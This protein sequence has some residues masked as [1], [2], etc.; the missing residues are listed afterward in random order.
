MMLSRMLKISRTV[1]NK[2]KCSSGCFTRV[3]HPCDRKNKFVCLIY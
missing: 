3:F 2:K 1:L